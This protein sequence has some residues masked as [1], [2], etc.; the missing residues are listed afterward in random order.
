MKYIRTQPCNNCPYR[1]DAPRRH[2]SAEEFKDL[3]KNDKLEYGTTY[4]CHKKDGHVC[5]GWLIDQ[6][7]RNLPS[8]ML[9]L[10]LSKNNV[11]RKYMDRLHCKSPM[12]KS[13]KEMAKANYPEEF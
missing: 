4:G 7:N 3:L 5:V 8:I 11:T 9:R 1:K 13:I 10:S 6:D 2:W 12:F